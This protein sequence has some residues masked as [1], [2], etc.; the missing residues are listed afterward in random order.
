MVF[1][2]NN[3]FQEKTTT[4][5]FPFFIFDCWLCT[6]L[7]FWKEKGKYSLPWHNIRQD[8][9]MNFRTSKYKL[10][11]YETP[12]GLK[13]IMNTDLNV[14][15]IRDVL[16]HI[17]SSVSIILFNQQFIWKR[18]KYYLL[19]SYHIHIHLYVFS[20]SKLSSCA[21]YTKFEADRPYASELS[22]TW[23]KRLTIHRLRGWYFC[24]F[25]KIIYQG[26]SS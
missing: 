3:F 16:Q 10:H 22:G 23:I 1:H 6:I 17:F 8:G 25:A 21:A 20:L 13:F 4:Y 14:G 15:N 12:S 7:H 26:T 19:M 11:F 18:V 5:I 24:I 2:F 9:F